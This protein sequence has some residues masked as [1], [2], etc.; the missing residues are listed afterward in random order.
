MGLHYPGYATPRLDLAEAYMEIELDPGLYIADQVAPEFGSAIRGG[1]YPRRKK[2]SLL[3]NPASTRRAVGGGFGRIHSLVGDG[4]FECET[5]GLE[6]VVDDEERVLYENEF[7]ADL[8]CVQDVHE[9]LSIAREIRVKDATFDTT[10]WTGSALYTDLSGSAPWATGTSDW[11][12]HVIDAVEKVRQNGHL[13]NA[14]IL[15]AAVKPHL[16]KSQVTR[17]QFPG[18]PRIT[19][20]MLEE[21]LSS[22]CGIQ[23]VLFGGARYDS[24]HA[25]SDPTGATEPTLTD[26]WGETYAM[27]ARV[28]TP[29]AR[30]SSP[31]ILRTVRWT[32]FDKSKRVIQYREEQTLGDVFREMESVDELQIDKTCGHLLKIKA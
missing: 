11:I 6:G 18:A 12:A 27:V 30:L 31:S 1:K 13:A 28:T 17:A 2:G 4:T 29:G 21:A 5:H 23:R 16:L 25:A 26:I 14:L 8:A 22:L 24:A 7:D 10:L 20:A 32:R 19:V 3:Q 9:A 15:G